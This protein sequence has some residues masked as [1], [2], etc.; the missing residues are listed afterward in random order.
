MSNYIEEASVVEA[1]E[2]ITVLCS[3]AQSEPPL[4]CQAVLYC[5]DNETTTLSFSSTAVQ[6][7][8]TSQSCN[9]TVQVVSPTDVSRVLQGV[10][11]YNVSPSVQPT[12]PPST[13]PSPSPPNREL[14][15]AV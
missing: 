2:N 11:F 12:S 7:F 3:L 9:V 8:T 5:A 13:S 6:N 10:A 1:V 14:P 4:I 15:I